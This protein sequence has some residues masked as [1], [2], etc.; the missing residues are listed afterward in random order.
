M[1]R[2]GAAV[3]DAVGDVADGSAV[4]VGGLGSSRR[5]MRLLRAL[6][7]A[8]PRDLAVVSFLGGL[9]VELLLAAG[10]VGELHT[11]GTSLDAAGLAPLYRE[12]RETGRPTVHEWGEGA[13]HAALEAAARGLP[14]LPTS[15]A[16]AS[17]VVATNPGLAVAE[18]PFGAGP[19]VVARALAVDL[20]LL[21]VP[22]ASERGDLFHDGDPGVDD[23]LVRAARRVVA[24]TDTRVQRPPADATVARI[25]VDRVVDLPGGSWPT[26]CPG[27]E[28]GDPTAA[29]RWTAA[30]VRRPS[31]LWEGAAHG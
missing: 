4:A 25:W 24:S 17:D 8:G 2:D 27:T 30:E 13:L 31:L 29:P 20:A 28:A 12:A 26:P 10:V 1:R 7:E 9:D 18:D 21:H 5:P 23:V 14:Y 6:V 15:T 3:R 19:V 11:A 22:A 16:V